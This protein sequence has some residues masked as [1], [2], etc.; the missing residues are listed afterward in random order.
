MNV[1][2]TLYNKAG[3]IPSLNLIKPAIA[4]GIPVGIAL[5][6]ANAIYG[7]AATLLGLFIGISLCLN[8]ILLVT[9]CWIACCG[10]KEYTASVRIIGSLVFIGLGL[11]T[12][13]L[14]LSYHHLL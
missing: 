3:F 2:S 12:L 5:L 6:A 14:N 9:G 1:M 11:L 4:L 8:V 7:T 13:L 10:K